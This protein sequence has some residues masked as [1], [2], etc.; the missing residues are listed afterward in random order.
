[1]TYKRANIVNGGYQTLKLKKK[2]MFATAQK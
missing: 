2:K 1:M